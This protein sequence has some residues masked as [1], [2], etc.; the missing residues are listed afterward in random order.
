MSKNKN[1]DKA[2]E[3]KRMMKKLIVLL[4]LP[5]F[6]ACQ[7][8]MAPEDDMVTV[9]FLPQIESGNILTRSQF[10]DEVL[11]N[12]EYD[13]PKIIRLWNSEK[14]Y[15]LDLS[16]DTKFSIQKG[17]YHLQARTG[18]YTTCNPKANGSVPL[19]SGFS[20]MG[21]DWDGYTY[22]ISSITI[23]ESA[24]YVIPLK[25]A[26]IIF[27]CNKQDASSFTWFY[28][29]NNGN[30]SHDVAEQI[31]LET[32]NYYY[33]IITLGESWYINPGSTVSGWADT[34]G[35]RLGETET[36]ESSEYTIEG[37]SFNCG[38]Y[39]I[40]K[41]KEKAMRSF[42]FSIGEWESGNDGNEN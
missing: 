4:F 26:G 22:M 20:R 28:K 23:N 38:K 27:A 19:A 31:L 8:E 10:S 25:I 12:L 5:L 39:F 42:N 9:S 6:L 2:S 11:D 16:K 17:S 41:P 29:H 15:T 7:K 30:T 18:K 24:E 40:V 3:R 32:E 14:S 37:R 21:D 34:I 33:Y 36:N 1:M 35:V 13:I